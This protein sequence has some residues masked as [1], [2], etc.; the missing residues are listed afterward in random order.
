[1]TVLHAGGKFDSDSYAVSG[2]LHG[3][4]VSVVN[5]LSSAIDVEI[6]TEG[7]VWR[8][9]YARSVPGPLRKGETTRRTGSS[10]TFWADPDIFETTVYNLETIRRR[11]QEMAFLNKGLTIMLRDERNGGNHDA[12][13]PDAEG[14]VA[15]VREYV[16]QL[17]GWVGRLR[18]APEQEQGPHPQEA[19]VVLRRG[20]RA[21]RRGRDAVELRLHRVGLHV[22]EHDQHPRGRHAR[23]GVP[24]GADLDGEPLRA[25]QEAAQ[26][27]GPGTVRRRHPRGAGRDRVGQGQGAPVR[28]P[29][30]DQAGQHRGQVVRAAHLQRVAG[31]LVR[32]QPHRGAHDRQ[33]VGAVRAGPGGRAQG[34]RA[35]P[36]QERGRPRR[37]A[38][39][40]GRLPQQRPGALRGL[41][42]GGRLRGRLGEVRPR[43]D[44]PG[45]PAD[46]RQDHQRREGAD[47][48]RPQEHRGP[49][50]HHG[51]GHRHPRRVRPAAS[52]AITR[53]C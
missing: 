16:F 47:R 26:G 1:M 8:Q 13:E 25:R 42:R 53:S 33:Q 7:Y 4:G 46:P 19:G 22:R 2:G 49:V 24:L 40:A 14:Y 48:P 28:G 29:D 50:D 32:A 10:V 38:G 27:Q 15:K 20:P 35:G 45:D 31:R 3:V 23:G 37:A 51:A 44:V 34:P 21:R 30:Q 5:A 43:L 6:H 52:C 18:R 36:P 17:P 9:H 41:H 12:E 39:Q 11:L